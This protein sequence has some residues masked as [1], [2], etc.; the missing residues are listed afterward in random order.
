MKKYFLSLVVVVTLC[1]SLIPAW[2]SRREFVQQ[3]AAVDYY[4]PGLMYALNA[5]AIPKQLFSAL[6]FAGGGSIIGGTD[7][8][9]PQTFQMSLALPGIAQLG[10]S[11][12][13]AT[14]KLLRM[15]EAVKLSTDVLPLEQIATLGLE[16]TRANAS[17]ADLTAKA[18]ART[19]A[20]EVAAK[21]LDDVKAD[22]KEARADKAKTK[23]EKAARERL[24]A[25]LEKQVTKAQ[26]AQAAASEK[27]KEA[28]DKLT[29][30]QRAQ[31]DISNDL[32]R[33][34]QQLADD[35]RRAGEALSDAFLR[36]VEDVETLLSELASGSSSMRDFTGDI[37]KLR[38]AGLSE[39]IIQILVGKGVDVGDTIAD[40]IL[41]G[42]DAMVKQLNDLAKK[43]AKQADLL[44][45]A[46]VIGVKKNADGGILEFMAS[47]G[48]R[49]MSP[50]AQMV[51][52]NT[53]RIVGD[54]S[55]VDELYAPL[56]GSARSWRLI[57]EG[58]ARMPGS[59]PHMLAS[60][61]LYGRAISAGTSPEI[62]ALIAE[63]VQLRAAL[64]SLTVVDAGGQLITTMQ[65]VARSETAG[66]V[67]ALRRR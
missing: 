19:A 42:G 51:P 14:S 13:V 35:A 2:I 16:L 38:K 57:M 47:G 5:R 56:D 61:A 48:L 62:G 52:P 33:A 30:A 46:A 22:L 34:H 7:A 65:V 25:S 4:G 26:T 29:E 21:H 59:P 32:T 53:W 15:S 1:T 40:G 50:L 64:S 37:E 45:L 27:A 3:A 63:V 66:L 18:R 44:G 41:A 31:A 60:G 39:D 8:F 6:G 54:R 55:D 67:S 11:L 20:E 12:S 17:V 36:D 24:V 43:F 9:S 58:L 49:P 10:T 23:S 28:T